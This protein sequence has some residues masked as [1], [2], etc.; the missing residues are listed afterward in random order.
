VLL[1]Y[2]SHVQSKLFVDTDHIMNSAGDLFRQ[3]NAIFWPALREQNSFTSLLFIMFCILSM[4][5]YILISKYIAPFL[6]DL[7]IL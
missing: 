3:Q 1:I 7:I 6:Q 4:Q 5:P 2:C